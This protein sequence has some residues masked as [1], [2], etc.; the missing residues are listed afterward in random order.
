M[1]YLD[2]E[3]EFSDAQAVTATAISANVI[4]LLAAQ[5]GGSAITADVTTSLPA[6]L[7]LNVEAAATFTGTGTLAVQLVSATDP[8]LV[9]GAVVHFTSGAVVGNTVL[10]GAKL[11]DCGIPPGAYK[12]YLGLRFVVSGTASGS[13]NAYLAVGTSSLR[14]YRG[15]FKVT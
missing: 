3:A 12:R 10:A 15:N 11:L 14:P 1:A 5:G 9:A 13:V 8:A 7:R 6:G 2:G 4:D